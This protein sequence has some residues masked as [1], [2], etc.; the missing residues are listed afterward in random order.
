M[1]GEV[2]T[3]DECLI[4]LKT[5]HFPQTS[6]TTRTTQSTTTRSTTTTSTKKGTILSDIIDIISS[7]NYEN[8]YLGLRV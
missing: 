2:L 8:T 5:G 1:N 4:L 3:I 7:N 6:E